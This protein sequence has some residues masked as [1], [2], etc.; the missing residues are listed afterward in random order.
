M[1]K[2]ILLLSFLILI[3]TGAG[4]AFAPDNSLFWLASNGP[5]FQY[6]RIVVGSLLAIQLVTRPP[7]HVWFRVLAGTV[8]ACTAYWAIGQTYAYHMQ[9]LDTLAFLGG[10]FTIAATALERSVHSFPATYL[11]NETI[12]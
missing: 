3:I 2:L 4:V 12:T 11:S 9:L 1:S 7:R 6:M 8:S 10:S 5:T